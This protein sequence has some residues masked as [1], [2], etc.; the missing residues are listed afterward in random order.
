[1]GLYGCTSAELLAVEDVDPISAG[2]RAAVRPSAQDVR[3]SRNC[4][5]L[6]AGYDP[7]TRDQLLAVPGARAAWLSLLSAIQSLIPNTICQLLFRE[8]SRR[9]GQPCARHRPTTDRHPTVW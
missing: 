3:V 2:D 6:H 5:G 9:P 4:H 1:L 8:L 7:S